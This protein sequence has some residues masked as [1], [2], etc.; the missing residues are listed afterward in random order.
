M[1]KI[2]VYLPDDLAARVREADISPSPLVQRCLEAE[3]ARRE[4]A[5]ESADALAPIEI[6]ASINGRGEPTR[7][8]FRGRVIAEDAHVTVYATA[9]S[10]IAVVDEKKDALY[11]YPTLDDLAGAM[12]AKPDLVAQAFAALGED[13]VEELNI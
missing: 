1:P 10:Q 7:K 4:G 11:V 6:W 9:K 2:T 12:A 5:T 8:R 13:F 3:L